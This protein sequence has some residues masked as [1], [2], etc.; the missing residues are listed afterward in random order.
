MLGS[1]QCICKLSSIGGE[2]K[3][4]DYFSIYCN[5]GTRITYI[6]IEVFQ[7]HTIASLFGCVMWR[8]WRRILIQEEMWHVIVFLRDHFV[9]RLLCGF[10]RFPCLVVFYS[11]CDQPVTDGFVSL[12]YIVLYRLLGTDLLNLKKI[13]TFI[14]KITRDYKINLSFR[15]TLN[16]FV[17]NFIFLYTSK[18]PWLTTLVWDQ[19]CF[20]SIRWIFKY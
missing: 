10:Q 1:I 4:N 3:S 19:I 9:Q 15:G 2:G 18:L 16:F 14:T 5:K 12:Y 17:T 13:Y 7:L 11:Q 8:L 20:S 6:Q